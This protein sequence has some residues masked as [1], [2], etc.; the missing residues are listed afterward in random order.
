M[1]LE[2]QSRGGTEQQRDGS[3]AVASC[4]IAVALAL[5]AVTCT[6]NVLESFYLRLYFYL[7]GYAVGVVIGVLGAMRRRRRLLALLG[8]A[9][10]VLGAVV[11]A[12]HFYY[13]FLDYRRQGWM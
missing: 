12:H 11:T 4:I 8:I 2:Y 1:K 3:F 13:L 9:L 10:N 7:T 6:F 5:L